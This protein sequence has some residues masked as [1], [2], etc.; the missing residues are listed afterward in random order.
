LEKSAAVPAGA[1]R[2]CD[3]RDAP[4]AVGDISKPHVLRRLGAL[5]GWFLLVG[6]VLSFAQGISHPYY[7]TEMAPAV[8]AVTA[9]GLALMWRSTAVRLGTDGACYQQR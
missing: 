3:H 2:C 6:L 5:G 7:T 8:T 1:G 9:A 4:D